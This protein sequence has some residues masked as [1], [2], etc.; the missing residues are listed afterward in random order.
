LKVSESP[1]SFVID[2]GAARFHVSRRRLQPLTQ[3][4]GGKKELLV[5]ADT[6]TFLT[7]AKGTLRRGKITQ[8]ALEARGP[9]RLTVRLE[10]LFEGS[11]LRFVA[12]L[13]FFGGTGL[14]HLRFT[15]HNP[16][17]ARHRGG[18]WDLG[19]PGSVLFKDLSLQW[20]LLSTRKPSCHWSAE[21]GQPS[22]DSADGHLEIYQDSSGGENWQS[23]SH[24]NRHGRIPCSFR[25]YRIRTD[26]DDS[27]GLRA[28]PLV[29]LNGGH[30]SLMVAVPE[31]WQQF[32]KAIEVDGH[33]LRVRLFPTQFADLFE[34]QGGE[35][36][37]HQL[38][39]HFGTEIA[40]Q[41]SLGEWAHQPVCVQ[42][43]P[44]WLMASEA[45]PFLL[46]LREDPLAQAVSIFAGTVSG[47]KSF[48]AR[49]ELI[50]E[51]GWRH[52]GEVYADHEA[53]FY[54]GP[55]PVVSHYN[56]QYDL[57]FGTIQQFLR[58]G[59]ARWFG[60]LDPLARH[61]IDIDIYHTVKDRAAYNGGLFWHTDHYRDAA[62]CTHRTYS[63]ANKVGGVPYGGGPCNEHNYTTGLLHYYF[64]TGDP[65]AREE[66]I[67]LAD[68]VIRMDDGRRNVFGL[69][70]DGPTGLA[71]STTEQGYHGP[72]RGCGNSINALLD[73]WLGSG[74][75]IY[76]AK[77]E[78][79]IRRTI[80]PADDIAAL[81]LLDVENRWSYT[82]FLSVLARYLAIK[83][84]A[85]ELDDMYTYGRAALLRYAAWMLA[86][87]SPYF[88]HPEKLE[89]PT[90]TWAA[91]DLRKAN[92][93]RLAACHADE[94]LKMCL[95]R[96][97]N[98]LADRAWADLHRFESRTVTRAL[99]ILLAEAPRDSY[100]R[101]RVVKPFPRPLN[102]HDLGLPEVFTPQR[103][104]IRAR[105]STIGG[106]GRALLALMNPRKWR[107]P[108][109][110]G[111][112]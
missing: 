48:F 32:P 15:L 2:T 11:P 13:S 87:E 1:Y 30:G 80:H 92:V 106:I 4:L 64:L 33:R 7:D 74:Q 76:L 29:C 43:S 94:P 78:S 54:Q 58:T 26:T 69:L 89:F 71:S 14:V 20:A 18:L 46:P 34:L 39:L 21:V 23:R 84:E 8:S 49:R 41:V 73:G 28:S 90:E 45:L 81:N 35:Q 55:A 98:E 109:P 110:L 70:D 59:D 105:L 66:V 3:V 19:D 47:E 10:G 102:E 85:G 83:A 103:Q 9:V 75:R 107:K 38:W 93:L 56:N 36:K 91:Q 31:F 42:A 50:D 60:I 108:F 52:F 37:T 101:A 68:W 40:D 67:G 88:D 27:F 12:R 44:D 24:V 62:S 72:G 61:I 16:N 95:W 77:A 5:P 82:V 25:G 99:A 63:R 79:L 96:R 6:G 57:L 86:N 51:F 100:F 97:G 17:R 104:R 53:A 111:L 112:V 22:C 65:T